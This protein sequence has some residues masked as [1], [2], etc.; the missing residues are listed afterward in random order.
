MT[1]QQLEVQRNV[2]GAKARAHR[3]AERIG[4]VFVHGAGSQPRSSTLRRNA[5][6][7]IRWL[8]RWHEERR[9]ELTVVSSLLSYGA[10]IDGPARI[11]LRIPDYELSP[12]RGRLGIRA[13]ERR[14]EAERPID[15]RA[16]RRFRSQ[17]WVLTEGWWAQRIAAP[18]FLTM[19]GW[20]FRAGALTF[21]RLV[22]QFVEQDPTVVY[23][24]GTGI[25]RAR[26]TTLAHAVERLSDVLVLALYW[27]VALLITPVVGLLYLIAQLPIPGLE[28]RI[29]LRLL[30]PL[31]IDSI[32]DFYTY[33]HDEPQALH[34]RRSVEEAVSWLVDREECEQ[35]ILVAH[36]TGTVVSY[37][38]LGRRDPSPER[39]H[40]V[41]AL[42]K[43]RALVTSG[44]V[45]SRAWDKGMGP[46]P[47]LRLRDPLCDHVRW[48]DIWA[49]YDLVTG[50][51]TKGPGP[52]HRDPD[53]SIRITNSL[54]LLRDHSGYWDNDEEYQPRIAQLIESPAE[55]H[56]SRFWDPLRTAWAVR[57]R[58]RVTTLVAWRIAGMAA[59]GAAILSRSLDGRIAAEGSALLDLAEPLPIVGGVIA[60]LRDLFAT[61][62][63]PP[64]VEAGAAFAVGALAWALA[65]LLLYLA[66][67]RVVF[68]PWDAR[69]RA[70]AIAPHVAPSGQ[71]AEIV[72]RTAPVLAALASLAYAVA[73]VRLAGV[74]FAGLVLLA[75]LFIAWW[76]SWIAVV[77]RLRGLT[78]RPEPALDPERAR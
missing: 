10:E 71:T 55:R 48:V 1:V 17:T 63:T 9:L 67:V 13:T 4:V 28:E 69:D 2:L 11:H 53:E 39:R 76:W 36:S 61:L 70:L 6:P 37:D 8:R 62:S 19:L 60:G 64:S 32:G 30:R 59:F 46:E 44:S 45:L 54:D 27:V 47:A 24:S 22:A 25:E 73:A 75:A 29:V 18:T 51:P 42:E 3:A 57:R 20:A 72:L 56:A 41:P 77:P 31:L 34:A 15:L 16:G 65:S 7:L 49:P 35:V 68:E 5:D 26:R 66:V 58:D 12:E 78:R 52:P 50:G 33:L 43:V 23:R 14:P 38:V 21:R 74:T 40:D